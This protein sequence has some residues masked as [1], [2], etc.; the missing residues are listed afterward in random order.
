MHIPHLYQVARPA[1]SGASGVNSHSD[2]LVAT[3]RHP[4]CPR[5]G[6]SGVYLRS[7]SPWRHLR[8]SARHVEDCQRRIEA[9]NTEKEII[10]REGAIGIDVAG[11]RTATGSG[12]GTM[13][14]ELPGDGRV[15]LRVLEGS[16][17]LDRMD[18]D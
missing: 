15:L 17:N 9:L 14:V 5:S 2:I 18:H 8:W 11:Y 16:V 7:R 6:G 13:P 3:S 12:Y 1:G 4:L 10:A